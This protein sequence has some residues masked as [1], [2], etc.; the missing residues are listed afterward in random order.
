MTANE[1]TSDETEESIDNELGTLTT[2]RATIDGA[3]TAVELPDRVDEDATISIDG[4]GLDDEPSIVTLRVRGAVSVCV[5]LQ[6]DEALEL[7]DKIATTAAAVDGWEG[8]E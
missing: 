5:S 8:D 1:S 4:H 2:E 6:A 7:A 3:Y